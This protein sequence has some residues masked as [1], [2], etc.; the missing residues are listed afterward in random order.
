MIEHMQRREPS[1]VELSPRERL[2][3]LLDPGFEE[4]VDPFCRVGSPWLERQGLVPQSDDGVIVVRGFIDGAETVAIAIE[5]SFEGGSIGEVGGAKIANALRLAAEASRKGN[6]T[7]ALMLLET[8]G[9]RLGEANLGL[10][11]IASIQTAIVELRELAPVIAV[12][13]GPTGCFGGM[14]LAAS[15]CTSIIGTPHGRLGMNGPEVIE[16]EAGPEELDATDRQQ[17]WRL[18]GCEARL[19]DG[20]VDAVSEDAAASVLAAV[21]HAL[22]VGVSPPKRILHERE[23]LAGLRRRFK[24]KAP[25]DAQ[26][27]GRAGR[28]LELLCGHTAQIAL[29]TPSVLHGKAHLNNGSHLEAA[30]ALAISPDAASA[31][32]RASHGEMGLEQA[33]AL[34]ACI[35]TWLEREDVKGTHRPILALVDTPGQAFGRIEEEL[36]ISAACASA[37]DAYAEARRAGHPVITLVVGKA[38]SG[39]F[40]A[41]GLQ[42][43][44][45]LALDVPGVIMHAMSQESIARITRRTVAE[46]SA[47]AE[48]VP[49]MSYSITQA[50][51]LGII[52]TL[53][54]DVPADTPNPAEVALVQA[55][56]NDALTQLRNGTLVDPTKDNPL[57]A[58]TA[59][60]EQ[61][62]RTQWHAI[63][64]QRIQSK[65]ESL[66]HAGNL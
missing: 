53:I 2:A 33:L 27:P 3:S 28:W 59:T 49:P 37:V 15:L 14:S 65:G 40:L 64:A 54:P 50:H 45:I 21:R 26:P 11:A 13:A 41:H 46:V 12:V 7:P 32:P 52:H 1:F 25:I 4:L 10:A 56:L 6:A 16:Q 35:R 58:A 5:P 23:R 8:G 31:F 18:V 63:D 57:R 55:A 51:Q 62:M 60:V 24:R 48:A 20:F 22:S 29:D 36:C 9:V 39:S 66:I 44:I 47:A 42:S 19:R 34:A 61:M 17:I 43:D 38:I 30:L